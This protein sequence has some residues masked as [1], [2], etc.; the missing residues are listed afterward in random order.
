MPTKKNLSVAWQGTL[1][2]LLSMLSCVLA[3]LYSGFQPTHCSINMPLPNSYPQGGLMDVLEYPCSQG[4]VYH[5]QE[6]LLGEREGQV[7]PSLF[8]H[9]ALSAFFC[10]TLCKYN[11]MIIQPAQ[12]CY[13]VPYRIFC[14]CSFPIVTLCYS[15]DSPNNSQFYV[16]RPLL[17]VSDTTSMKVIYCPDQA[18]HLCFFFPSGNVLWSASLSYSFYYFLCSDRCQRE[19][20]PHFWNDLSDYFYFLL[21]QILSSFYTPGRDHLE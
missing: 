12:W 5:I 4:T 7:Q 20:R 2:N 6:I 9:Q 11:D 8:F 16:F 14:V 17:A 13:G 21:V 10:S 1:T 3:G 19:L 15:Q 18:L